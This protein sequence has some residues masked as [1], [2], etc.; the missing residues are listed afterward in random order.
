MGKVDKNKRCLLITG[1]VVPNSN[2]VAHTDPSQRLEEYYEAISFYASEFPHTDLYFLENSSYDFSENKNFQELFSSGR[3]TLMKFPVS[4]KYSEGKGYQEF[5]MLDQ[6]VEKLSDKYHSFIKLTG[7]YK[8]L[9]LKQ[10]TA[11]ATKELVIDSHKK[12]GVSQTNVFLCTFDYY[13]RHLKGLYKKVNDGAG[14][15][16]EKIVYDEIFGGEGEKKTE[17]FSLNPII[18]G[19]SGSYGGSLNRNKLKM[20]LRNL[21]RKFLRM[22]GIK[23]FLIEY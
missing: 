7:R 3:V 22:F 16:I 11:S 17:L 1:T 9:N 8:V 18:K 13:D 5:E 6:A 20:K 2:F 15:Y 10:I 4:G 21:E 14:V 12:P 23:R 19:V